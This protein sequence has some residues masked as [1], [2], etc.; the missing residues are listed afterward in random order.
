[1][2]P[3][4]K[5]VLVLVHPQSSPISGIEAKASRS[6]SDHNRLIRLNSSSS[7]SM[8]RW[9]KNLQSPAR[10]ADRSSGIPT[11]RFERSVESIDTKA[12]F[13]QRRNGV[14]GVITLSKIGLPYLCSPTWK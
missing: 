7:G 12:A 10:I 2:G 9:I 1:M 8:R 13:R 6:A 14:S 5:D 11:D 4:L 3:E